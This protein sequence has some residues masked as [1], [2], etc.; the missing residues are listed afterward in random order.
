MKDSHE[1]KKLYWGVGRGYESGGRICLPKIVM[2]CCGVEER[3]LQKPATFLTK[4][5]ITVQNLQFKHPH[6]QKQK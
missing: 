4:S 3:K 5:L 2:S 6:F 1:I